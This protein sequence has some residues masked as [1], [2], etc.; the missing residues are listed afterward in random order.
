[1]ACWIH[2]CSTKGAKVVKIRAK[3][4]TLPTNNREVLEMDLDWAHKDTAYKPLLQVIADVLDSA[5][6]GCDS[7]LSIG[8]TRDKSSVCLMVQIDGSRDTVY[9]TCLRDMDEQAQTLL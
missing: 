7:F 5:A 9:S 3:K 4:E 1:V 6:S 8:A 2:N